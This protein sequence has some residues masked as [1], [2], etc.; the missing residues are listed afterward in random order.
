M[1]WDLISNSRPWILMIPCKVMQ[2]GLN[3]VGDSSKTDDDVCLQP[4]CHQ[5]TGPHQDFSVFEK[6][7]NTRG[8]VCMMI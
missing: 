2:L 5:P 4:Q 8:A 3:H 1:T 7:P 6:P